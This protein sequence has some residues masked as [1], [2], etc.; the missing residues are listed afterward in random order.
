[1]RPLEKEAN[2]F[3]CRVSVVLAMASSALKFPNPL[4]AQ[5]RARLWASIQYMTHGFKR[6]YYA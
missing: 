2:G 4:R 5:T 3:C 1:M 6:S